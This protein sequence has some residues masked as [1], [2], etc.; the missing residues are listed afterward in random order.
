MAW[1]WQRQPERPL[2]QRV[3]SL[4]SP[5]LLAEIHRDEDET[6]PCLIYITH[7]IVY[8]RLHVCV[9]VTC[10]TCISTF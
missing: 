3:D 8:H 9:L 2:Q 10:Y 1:L 4:E 6:V 7:F 5:S